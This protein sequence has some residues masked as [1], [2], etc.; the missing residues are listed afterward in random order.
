MPARPAAERAAL[1]RVRGVGPT[2]VARLEGIGVA[3]L[4]DLARR[5]PAALAAEIA[6]ATGG[7]TCWR[8]SPLAR[9]ALAGAVE[10]AAREVSLAGPR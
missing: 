10:A 4:A 5:D 9:A 3:G 2:V 6:R 7:G 8:N 1:L